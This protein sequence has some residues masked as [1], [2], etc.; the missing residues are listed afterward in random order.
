MKST[1]VVALLLG[2]GLTAFAQR[3]TSADDPTLKCFM[4]LDAD[5]R[6]TV[7]L[8]RL[9]S[10]PR[11][12]QATFEMMTSKDKPTEAE[13]AA[14]A[15]LGA[16][17]QQCME[18]GRNF[19]SQYAVPGLALA[20]EAG[21]NDLLLALAQLHNG[22]ISYG[23]YITKRVQIGTAM[24]AKMQDADRQNQKAA[25]QDEGLR[26]AQQDAARASET[27]NTLQIMRMLQPQQLPMPSRPPV[28]CRSY[29][30][31]NTIQTDCN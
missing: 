27:N 1:L 11:G 29:R 14:L 9:G 5:P 21:Q 28:S 13:K 12:N 17:R 16:A 22:E 2:L 10:V 3:P 6:F 20:L 18:L 7:L 8:P 30:L 24:T 19:R 15:A 4:G 25:A 23:E 26:R 31:G